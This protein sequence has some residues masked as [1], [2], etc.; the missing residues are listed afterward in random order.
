MGNECTRDTALLQLAF[1]SKTGL[2]RAL[3]WRLPDKKRPL[4]GNV[5]FQGLLQNHKHACSERQDRPESAS[6]Y[7]R[8]WRTAQPLKTSRFTASEAVPPRPFG[9]LSLV[10]S[11]CSW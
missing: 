6:L 8:A 11:R 3:M 4:V 9:P 10:A 5:L 1:A 7:E 2:G